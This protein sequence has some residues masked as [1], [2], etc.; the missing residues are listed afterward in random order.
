MSKYNV[1]DKAVVDMEIDKWDHTDNSY[2]V[3]NG[4]S[5]IWVDE[6]MLRKAL[7]EPPKFIYEQIKRDKGVGMTLCQ[8]IQNLSVE[9]SDEVQQW[10]FGKDLTKPRNYDLYAQRQEE[11]AEAWLQVKW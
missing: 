3:K 2:R 10:L 5:N 7:P 9:N 1:G 4:M 8:S 6:D 11:I